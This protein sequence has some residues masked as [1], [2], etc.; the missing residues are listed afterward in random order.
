[1]LVIIPTKD[2]LT[3]LLSTLDSILVQS[4]L[5][6][7][8]LIVD[9]SERSAKKEL[10]NLLE[11]KKIQFT[12]LHAFPETGLVRAKRRGVETSLEDLVC[13]LEDDV[14]LDK[15]FLERLFQVFIDKP[16]A[17]GVGGVCRNSPGKSMA[18]ACLHWIFYRG[19][20]RDSRPWI[21]LWTAHE[22]S[23]PVLSSALSGGISAWRREVLSAV[24]FM[25]EEGFHMMEDLHYSRKV[26]ARCGPRLWIHPHA[27][28][29]HFPGQ[30]GRAQTGEFETRRIQEIFAFYRYHRKGWPDFFSFLWLSVGMT[31]FSIL[32]CFNHASCRPILG[33]VRG[34]FFSLRPNG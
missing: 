30:V 7:R 13:F 33:H 10:Q 4:R 22:G 16:E 24:P 32:K 17:L 25:A 14:V 28:L 23:K 20:F 27:T 12:Y 18:Y 8:I 3:S 21:T 9:Q 2:R 1:M 29:R 26:I 5:P 34:L 6:T 19:I 31:F 11:K 15:K